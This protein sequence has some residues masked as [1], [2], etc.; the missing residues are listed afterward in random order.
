MFSQAQADI[1]LQMEK[2]VFIE[3]VMVDQYLINQ[4]N[5]LHLTI[6]LT[7]IENQ[8]IGFILS[9][10]QSE[11]NNMKINLHHQEDDT[12]TGLLRLDYGGGHKNPEV[13]L[14]NVPQK[15]H[16]YVGY[17]FHP[18]EAHMHYYIDG[19]RSLDWALPLKEDE[20]TIKQI[21]TNKDL[22]SAVKEFAKRINII[23]QIQFNSE[24]MFL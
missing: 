7:D 1:L 17:I 9:V 21:S 22:L 2:K 13:L 20:F 23:T 19:Y 5:P 12:K 3:R 18:A 15:F 14:P 6:P 10:K 4:S 8:G 11:K 24:E 16:P